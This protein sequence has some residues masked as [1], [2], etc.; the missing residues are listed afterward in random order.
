MG[1]PTRE[2]F[3]KYGGTIDGTLLRFVGEY[4]NDEE[5]SDLYEIELRGRVTEIDTGR[6]NRVRS[7]L[8]P[9]RSGVPTTNS[10]LTTVR[11]WRLIY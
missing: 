9:M 1:G 11:C 2:L 10:A 5:Q 6:Q 3:L 4:Y 8:T 7:R